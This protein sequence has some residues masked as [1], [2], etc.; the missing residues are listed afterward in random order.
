MLAA[1]C[2][3]KLAT[4]SILSVIIISEILHVSMVLILVSQIP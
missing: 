2:K 4:S 1:L 3:K